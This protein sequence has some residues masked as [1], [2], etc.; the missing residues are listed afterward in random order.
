MLSRDTS[1]SCVASHVENYFCSVW[2]HSRLHLSQM[3]YSSMQGFSR[4]ENIQVPDLKGLL[5]YYRAHLRRMVDSF[6]CS[7][8]V[9]CLLSVPRGSR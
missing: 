1:V 7:K 4:E 6:L 3:D 2:Q 5:Q 9:M 8:S